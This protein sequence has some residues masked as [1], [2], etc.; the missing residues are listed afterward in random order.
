MRINRTI[1]EDFIKA[2]VGLEPYLRVGR[3][4][5]D[6]QRMIVN[7]RLELAPDAKLL[8]PI[9]GKPAPRY[10][11]RDRSWRHLDIF[12]RKCILHLKQPRLN[13]PTCGIK[14]W[15]PSW[16]DAPHFTRGFV[17]NLADWCKTAP[18]LQVA[19]RFGI[20]D[21]TAAS[22]LKIRAALRPDEDDE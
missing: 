17:D 22:N 4:E 21:K 15:N 20:S 12:G 11:S 19:L 8:C 6:M 16:A 14:S 18:V 13:C 2:D 10:D 9:C 3:V 7:V 5:F 1:F